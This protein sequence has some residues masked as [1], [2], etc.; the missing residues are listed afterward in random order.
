MEVV[1]PELPRLSVEDTGRERE[2]YERAFG[3]S[4]SV[5]QVVDQPERHRI[6]AVAAAR[7]LVRSAHLD[8][9]EALGGPPC[10]QGG[11]ELRD[12]APNAIMGPEP[13]GLLVLGRDKLTAQVLE[14]VCVEPR[15]GAVAGEPDDHAGELAGAAD[16]GGAY[17]APR[18]RQEFGAVPQEDTLDGG[19]ATCPLLD[20]RQYRRVQVLAKEPAP[21]AGS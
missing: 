8:G 16:L 21:V 18:W 11:A 13:E 17:V 14:R 19:V 4:R 10:V 12:G 2:S 6:I 15:G 20:S 9:F 7:A 1:V 5:D 3:W